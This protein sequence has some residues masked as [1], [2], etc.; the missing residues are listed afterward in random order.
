MLRTAPPYVPGSGGFRLSADLILDHAEGMPLALA[1]D[2]IGSIFALAADDPRGRVETRANS[3]PATKSV[4]IVHVR[5]PLEQRATAHLCGMTDGYDAIVERF[6]RALASPD[7]GAVLLSIDSPGGAVAGLF[8][9]VRHMRELKERSG[10]PVL[11]Y[12]DECAA[13]GG[14]AL[15][16]VADE[17]YL[18]PSGMLGSI[19][20][21]LVHREGSAALGK[22]GIRVTEFASGKRKTLGSPFRPLTDADKVEIQARID[23]LGRQFAALVAEAR[24]TTATAM[25]ALEGG[26]FTGEA[27]VNAGL[28]NGVKTRGEVLARCAVAARSPRPRATP[29][30]SA[31][32]TV[33]AGS[34]EASA[35]PRF[36]REAEVEM[37]IIVVRS[38]LDRELAQT[39]ATH[40]LTFEE[41][42]AAGALPSQ[43]LHQHDVSRELLAR[44]AKQ[45]ITEAEHDAAL[46]RERA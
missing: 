27:A 26:M 38:E 15:A 46:A 44:L 29:S 21:R 22:Q 25:L 40:G 36:S 10:K 8:E 12:A 41:A 19:G 4:A 32:Q 35:L 17:I 6:G 11:A 43:N 31:A 28:A 5:G 13:S 23:A 1:G 7:V 24:K 42:R 37:A 18:P 34:F 3:G 20:I 16:T 39:L 2:A 30:A 33:G 45:G 9:A 14:Y